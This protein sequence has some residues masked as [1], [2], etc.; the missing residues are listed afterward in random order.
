MDLI[1]FS[2]TLG[3]HHYSGHNL[4]DGA[5]ATST[6]HLQDDQAQESGHQD[7]GA[8]PQEVHCEAN[9]AQQDGQGK[10]HYLFCPATWVSATR[11]PSVG[12]PWWL[13]D[14]PFSHFLLTERRRGLGADSPAAPFVGGTSAIGTLMSPSRGYDC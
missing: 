8:E 1:R 12:A 7:N 9:H 2:D 11:G 5:F 10:K 14:Q 6:S 13:S 4:R 3:L